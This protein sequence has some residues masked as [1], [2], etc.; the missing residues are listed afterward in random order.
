MV[1]KVQRPMEDSASWNTQQFRNRLT[2]LSHAAIIMTLV[3]IWLIQLVDVLQPLFIALGTYF[4]LKPGAD[5]LSKKGFP[6]MLSY[7]TML[8]LAILI[9][10]GFLTAFLGPMIFATVNSMFADITDE[11]EL[12][13]GHRRE[14]VIFAVRGFAVK[15]NSSLGIVLGGFLLDLIAFPRGAKMGTVSDDIVWQLGFIAGPATSVFSTIG[16]LCYLFYR[17]DR[18]RHQEI[19]SV[20]RDQKE[21]NSKGEVPQCSDEAMGAPSAS[22]DEAV[23]RGT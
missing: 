22:G 5:F 17:I 23:E 12:E 3:T 13:T 1:I 19:L 10:S 9:V 18:K 2:V 15:V 6:L 8:M 11:H 4:V 21:Q 16:V 14:G 7:I 20:L